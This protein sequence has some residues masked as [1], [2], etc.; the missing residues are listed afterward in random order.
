MK[1]VLLYEATK[2]FMS[3]VPQ[4]IAAHRALWQKFHG[5]GTLMMVGPFMDPPAGGAMGI[6]TTREAAE[7]F[8]AA[9]PFVASGIVAR[10]SIREW[11][12]VLAPQ[13]AK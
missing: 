10:H 8:V 6:F 5:E 7:A 4:N 11:N 2:D 1:Y 3:K 9:D 12:E 13:P